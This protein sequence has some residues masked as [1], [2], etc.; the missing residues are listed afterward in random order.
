MATTYGFPKHDLSAAIAAADDLAS[1]YRDGS[2]RRLHPD[3]SIDLA[4]MEG[5]FRRRFL[6]YRVSPD[7]TTALV[8]SAGA[9]AAYKGF[10]AITLAG[11]ALFAGSILTAIML[12]D[13]AHGVVGLGIIGFIAC[14]IGAI[15]SNRFDLEW[16]IRESSGSDS[17]WQA[18][19]G[20]TKWAPRSVDQL[21]AVEQLA[22]EHGGKALA[23][24]HPDE[25][26]EVRTLK[27][28][29]T[30]THVVSL[31]GTVF[32]LHRSRPAP[33]YTLGAAAMAIGVG[34]AVIATLL[35]NLADLEVVTAFYMSFGLF[36][37]GGVL[38]SVVTLEH[39]SKDQAAVPGT[40][41]RRS[42]TTPTDGWRSV[43]SSARKWELLKNRRTLDGGG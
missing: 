35:Y 9:P 28:G 43:A 15:R 25:G 3:G 4:A 38:R 14:F 19:F 40:S 17:G 22:D 21:R 8:E 13:A 26:T 42:R 10:V 41:S 7:G 31:D 36:F 12:G 2:A 6:L 34:G 16:Y 33:L 32:L 20:P 24:A 23:R 37:V 39:R 5:W 29:R 30:Q 11:A 1:R 27:R 18:L